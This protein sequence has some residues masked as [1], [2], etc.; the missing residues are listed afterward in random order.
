M[1]L[2]KKKEKKKSRHLTGD[3]VPPGGPAEKC[4]QHLARYNVGLTIKAQHTVC[5]E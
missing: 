3:S 5:L 4:T 2:L 1:C